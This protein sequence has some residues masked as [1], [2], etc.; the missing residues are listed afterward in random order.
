MQKYLAGIL[1]NPNIYYLCATCNENKK[2][3]ETI[4]NPFYT[5]NF[6]NQ[7]FPVGEESLYCTAPH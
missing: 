3:R 6:S 4:F 7:H 1:A 2:H 5:N